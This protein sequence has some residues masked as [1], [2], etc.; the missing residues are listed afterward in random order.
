MRDQLV[1]NIPNN[2]KNKF[3]TIKK[4]AMKTNQG[5]IYHTALVK[6]VS[7]KLNSF[8]AVTTK[9][10]ISHIYLSLTELSRTIEGSM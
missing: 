5:L 6:F 4:A 7:T 10:K 1:C 8:S 3:S 9:I 2:I